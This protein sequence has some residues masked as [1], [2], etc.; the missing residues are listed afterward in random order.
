MK[1]A[2]GAN[3]DRLQVIKGWTKD[4][5]TFEEIY[6]VAL[7][8]GRQPDASGRVPWSSPIWYTL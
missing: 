3:L 5:K 2:D 1:E 4:G 7:S 6:D 8:D